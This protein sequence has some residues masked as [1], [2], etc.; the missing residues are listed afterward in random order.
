MT[1]WLRR[2][3]LLGYFTLT[4]GISWVGI[5]IVFVT[6]SFKL[7]TLPPRETGVGGGLM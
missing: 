5:L 1:S 7:A 4:F 6:T 2:H 3:R